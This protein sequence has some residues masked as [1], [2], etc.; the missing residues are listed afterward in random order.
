MKILFIIDPPKKLNSR[1]DNSLRLACEFNRRGHLCFHADA[2]DIILRN[3]KVWAKVHLMR[4]KGRKRILPG[5]LARLPADA[6]DLIIIRKEP[7]VDTAYIRMTRLLEK[8]SR[9][10]PVINHPR[11]IRETNE[12]LAILNFPK[13]I[14]KTMVT[15]SFEAILQFQKKIKK[16]IVIKPLDQKGG[17]GVFKIQGDSPHSR[18]R[19]LRALSSGRKKLMVQEFVPSRTGEKRIVLM[20]GNVFCLYEKRPRGKEFRANLSLGAT[21]HKALLTRREKALCRDLKPFLLKHGLEFVGI[22]VLNG[23]LIEIN[24][25]SPAG[26]T[27]AIILEPKRALLESWADFLEDFSAKFRERKTSPK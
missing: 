5:A 22:D 9:K 3:G 1:W 6:F 16:P 21:F 15:S 11:G 18:Y 27:E 25:T 20:H 17:K 19:V 24:V 4:S 7:P 8:I 2:P 10:I 12:K 13:W 26:V 14:P 23:K